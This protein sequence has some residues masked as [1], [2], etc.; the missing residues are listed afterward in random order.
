MVQSH[1]GEDENVIIELCCVCLTESES[2]WVVLSTFAQ[3]KKPTSG[4]PKGWRFRLPPFSNADRQGTE[5]GEDFDGAA[6]RR[7]N[8]Y[9]CRDVGHNRLPNWDGYERSRY[10][11]N[12]C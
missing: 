12:V 7:D 5:G 1:F 2:V 10:G 9:C 8:G 3:V 4:C 6:R 11:L